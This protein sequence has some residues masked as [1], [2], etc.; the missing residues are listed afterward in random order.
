MSM[1]NN[2]ASLV[3]LRGF[4]RFVERTLP[5]TSTLYRVILAEK[6]EITAESFL[7][8][9]E[10]WLKQVDISSETLDVVQYSANR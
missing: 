8:N 5:W 10:V 9:S 2:P 4:K 6:D 1:E 3:N 7:S